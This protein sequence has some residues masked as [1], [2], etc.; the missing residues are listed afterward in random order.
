MRPLLSRLS[1][2]VVWQAVAPSAAPICMAAISPS[3]VRF[4]QPEFSAWYSS[5]SRT[6][7][8]VRNSTLS[9]LPPVATMMPL[10][11]RMLIVLPVGWN[12]S[13][14]S[15]AVM[16]VTRPENGCSRWIVVIRCLSRISTP[17][18]RA[19]LRQRPHEA[20]AARRDWSTSFG[21]AHDS[22]AACA[23]DRDGPAAADSLPI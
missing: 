8:M 10:R 18:S 21:Q 15:I 22:S 1:S 4:D 23:S 12:L 17:I 19:V 16:P 11:A 9:A 3:A 5:V 20:R 13:S 7:N 14:T 2:C 6:S